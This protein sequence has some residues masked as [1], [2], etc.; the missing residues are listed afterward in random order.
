MSKESVIGG[1][2]SGS[3]FGFGNEFGAREHRG[4]AV[5]A[6]GGGAVSVVELGDCFAVEELFGFLGAGSRVTRCHGTTI[7]GIDGIGVNREANRDG[8]GERGGECCL[9]LRTE[10]FASGGM[11]GVGQAQGCL[12]SLD[13]EPA[14]GGVAGTGPL[15]ERGKDGGAPGRGE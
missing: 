3:G 6:A 9:D 15:G 13:G 1:L 14:A 11:W 4:D 2:R 7:A 5:E 12:C 8:A 10:L